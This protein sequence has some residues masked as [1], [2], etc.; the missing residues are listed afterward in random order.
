MSL[1]KGLIDLIESTGDK[2]FNIH[3]SYADPKGGRAKVVHKV[4]HLKDP[5]HAR[6]YAH[7]KL[8]PKYPEGA[9]VSR[10]TEAE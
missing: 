1:A 4:K 2:T 7:Y 6:H 3:V 10:V 8:L 9:T 5:D